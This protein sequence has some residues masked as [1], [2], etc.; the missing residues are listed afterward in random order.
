MATIQDDDIVQVRTQSWPKRHKTIT[1]LCSENTNVVLA[2]SQEIL[3]VSLVLVDAK[4]RI[5][6][7][8]YLFARKLR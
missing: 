5:L 2:N 1:L 6:V 7:L 3:K 4:E 8:L